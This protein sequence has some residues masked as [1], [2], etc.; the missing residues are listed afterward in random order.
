MKNIGGLDQFSAAA[1]TLHF[2]NIF[3]RRKRKNVSIHSF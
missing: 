2:L 1:Q 3:G